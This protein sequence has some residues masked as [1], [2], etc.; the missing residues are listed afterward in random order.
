MQKR[1]EIDKNAECPCG[2]G[3][4]YRS[5]CAL[6]NFKW[7]INE[8][9]EL[10]Q[11]FQLTDEASEILEKQE[12]AFKR[13]FGRKMRPN[14]PI[15]FQTHAFHSNEA[16]EL[17]SE[18]IFDRMEQDPAIKYANKRLGGF[19]TQTNFGTLTGKQ[20]EEWLRY[21]NEYHTLPPDKENLPK[22]LNIS[23]ELC[24]EFFTLIYL[25]SNILYKKRKFAKSIHSLSRSERFKASFIL[26]CFAKTL[27]HL[28]S[29]HQ[30]LNSYQGEDAFILIRSIFEN[31]LSSIY[32]IVS[33]E[34]M[35]DTV[36]ARIGL[37]DG[38][39]SYKLNKKKKPIY[40]IAI[41]NSTG[42]EIPIPISFYQM[43]KKSPFSDDV[44]LYET[45]YP[46]LSGYTHPDLI[47]MSTY[48][49]MN[50][51]NP[52][53]DELYLEVPLNAVFFTILLIDSFY[54][55]RIATKIIQKDIK[56]VLKRI[57]SLYFQLY[58][59]FSK[60]GVN[61]Y[62]SEI[63]KDRLNSLSVLS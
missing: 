37:K 18:S 34:T 4:L 24:E 63:W 17:Y 11:E 54:S 13:H 21:F 23:G 36:K 47:M 56:R 9:G 43:A 62:T 46:T 1:I 33:P 57:S 48:I 20:K 22:E 59:E 42:R 6:Q 40:S 49:N 41:E 7:T 3:E 44:L 25:I 28:K 53:H 50:D 45:L 32:V 52:Y 15:F 16:F 58:N 35:H 29:I 8:K 38:T 27:K 39:Y 26:F 2:S 10:F 5:C 12:A 14:E 60:Q 51:I 31:Y 61:E 19:V 55:L 30:L